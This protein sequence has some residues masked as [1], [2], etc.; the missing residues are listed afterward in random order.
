[1][2][3][4]L[5]ACPAGDDSET[6]A[7]ASTNGGGE[8]GYGVATG[9]SPGS[10]L[11]LAGCLSVPS[12]ADAAEAGLGLLRGGPALHPTAPRDEQTDRRDA[13]QFHADSIVHRA[14]GSGQRL[15]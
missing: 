10:T 12:P 2:R 1:M 3:N 6:N 13:P 11:R 14:K 4:S 9:K 8:P 5:T 15:D 7:S